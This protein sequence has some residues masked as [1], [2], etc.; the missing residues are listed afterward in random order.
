L[1]W[2]ERGLESGLKHDDAAA[3]HHHW[4]GHVAYLVRDF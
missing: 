2:F 3:A 4:V 1:S